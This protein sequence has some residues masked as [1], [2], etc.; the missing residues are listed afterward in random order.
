[1]RFD[2][3]QK[4][5]QHLDPVESQVFV[6]QNGL[7]DLFPRIAPGSPAELVIYPGALVVVKEAAYYSMVLGNRHLCSTELLRL[8]RMLFLF[9]C[10]AGRLA[11]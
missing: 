10:K 6:K 5:A 9:G 2:E 1:M 3:W 11:A 7:A 8:E 4:Q